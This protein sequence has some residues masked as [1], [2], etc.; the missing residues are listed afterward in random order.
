MWNFTQ[1]N[2][3]T[4]TLSAR[5]EFHFSVLFEAQQRFRRRA[6]GETHRETKRSTQ[7][8]RRR[9]AQAAGNRLIISS[10]LPGVGMVDE[11]VSPAVAMTTSI[12]RLA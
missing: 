10:A 12:V 5:S 3:E 2:C 9:P 11:K 4:G 8:S 6:G 1:L 7:P